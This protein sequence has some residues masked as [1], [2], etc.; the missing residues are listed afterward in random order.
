MNR[1]SFSRLF[2]KLV[3][4]AAMPTALLRSSPAAAE[5]PRFMVSPYWPLWLEHNSARPAE[6]MPDGG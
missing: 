3:A 4:L 1:R 5:G 2:G 6:D